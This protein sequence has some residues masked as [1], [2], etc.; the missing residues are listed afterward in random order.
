MSSV[1]FG[2]LLADTAS[3]NV[4]KISET[5][6]FFGGFSLSGDC[7]RLDLEAASPCRL[8]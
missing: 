1:P 4:S 3:R 5:A 8:L 7:S 6:S 2:I